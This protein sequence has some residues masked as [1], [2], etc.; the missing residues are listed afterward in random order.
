MDL[1][2]SILEENFK[3]LTPPTT[4]KIETYIDTSSVTNFVVD[5]KDSVI[6]SGSKITEQK[7]DK[8]KEKE[9]SEG[10]KEAYLALF[11]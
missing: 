7:V 4:R 3:D 1:K 10:Y 8:L 2:K 11:H 6:S 9:Q 5:E